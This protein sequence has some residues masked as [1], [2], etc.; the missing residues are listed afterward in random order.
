MAEHLLVWCMICNKFV[1]LKK[2]RTMCKKLDACGSTCLN[3]AQFTLGSKLKMNNIYQ[4][5]CCRVTKS[6]VKAVTVVCR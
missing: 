3:T 4:L 6:N 1:Y 5:R 2:S